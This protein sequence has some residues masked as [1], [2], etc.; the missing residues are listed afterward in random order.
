MRFVSEEKFI[1][2]AITIAPF[3]SGF[4]QRARSSYFSNAAL[5]A[6]IHG[7]IFGI[8]PA[9]VTSLLVILP[10]SPPG[11]S[12]LQLIFISVI[13]CKFDLFQMFV[14]FASFILII[15]EF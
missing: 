4:S 9:Q 5:L 6:K 7:L 14:H 8:F 12:I 10:S 3:M 13:C 11:N 15:H 1:E 2:M